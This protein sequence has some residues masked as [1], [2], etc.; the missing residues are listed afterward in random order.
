[1]LDQQMNQTLETLD[2]ERQLRISLQDKLTQ[3]EAKLKELNESLSQAESRV[4]DLS[5]AFAQAEEN[6]ARQKEELTLLTD[7]L[8]DRDRAMTAI[9]GDILASS[10]RVVEKDRQIAMI[11]KTTRQQI[12]NQEH[13]FRTSASWRFTKPLRFAGRILRLLRG[14]PDGR[15]GTKSS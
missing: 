10:A 5:V 11:K 14:H 1:M 15:Q 6:Q 8:I 7:R 4:S 13:D 3:A 9:R 2:A 12:K